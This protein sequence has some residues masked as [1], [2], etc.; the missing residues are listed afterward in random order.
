MSK[1][2]KL[3][4]WLTVSE[5][6]KHLSV[7]FGEEVAESDLLRLGLDGNLDLSV[8]L[9]EPILGHEMLAVER[10][11]IAVNVEKY[12]DVE[13]A[14][15]LP[16]EHGFQSDGLDDEIPITAC[17]SYFFND[18]GLYLT[19]RTCLIDGVW[20]LYMFG[21]E[22]R[23]IEN[24]YFSKLVADQKIESNFEGAFLTK[25][26]G[27]VYCVNQGE[28]SLLFSKNL[29]A[30]RTAAL[31][32]FEASLQEENKTS[33]GASSKTPRVSDNTLVSTIAALLALFPKGKHPSGKDLERA[34]EANGIS[35]SDDSIRKALKAAKELAPSLKI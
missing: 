1:L 2:F 8:V 20:D 10:E 32:D 29:L 30:V 5:A 11:E 17:G 12:G 35:I 9:F 28:N 25:G 4:E 24:M 19:G 21:S 15:I 23:E 31:M 16:L 6:A 26:D 33:E 34:A 27:R 7:L 22:K 3:K 18:W 13:L 14:P